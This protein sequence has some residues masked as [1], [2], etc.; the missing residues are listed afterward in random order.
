MSGEHG[1]RD[2]A[3]VTG[4][5]SGIGRSFA[6]ALAARG[7]DLLVTGRRREHI[8]AAAAEIRS[9][10]GVAV[11][12]RILEL[13]DRDAMRGFVR[14]VAS[15]E[16]VAVLVN[17]AGYGRSSPFHEDDV[18]AE[19]GMVTVHVETTLRLTHAVI[20]A[21]RR[22][23]GGW[24]INVS[25]LA[26][27]L[28]LPRGAV[29]ASTKAWMVGFSESIALELAGSGVRC[30]ALLP[31]FTRTDFHRS[32]QYGNLDRRNRGLV[33]WMEPDEVVSASLR[34][35]ERGRR[36]V[37]IPGAVNRVVAAAVRL[38]PRRVL[39]RLIARNRVLEDGSG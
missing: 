7:Y 6:A 20:P 16:H 39:Y 32:P 5:T 34:A 11:D 21:M 35:I 18:E 37:C 14:E 24:I 36:I 1:S 2:L 12:V 10:H 19:A 4:A 15:R 3:V 13:T 31:G 17:N 23:G 9:I 26:S 25:S 33:R 38:I 27:Y 30:Q 22:R 29:Y 8:E 28:P